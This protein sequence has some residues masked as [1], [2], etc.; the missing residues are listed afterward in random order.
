MGK[1]GEEQP[2]PT[3]VSAQNSEHNAEN[4]CWVKGVV[5]LR[6]VFVLLLGVAVLLSAVFW[7]PPFFRQRDRGDLDL[8]SLFRGGC[9]FFFNVMYW[10]VV[11]GSLHFVL[12]IDL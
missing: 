12:D 6:C 3:S 10:F 2:T 7:L 11:S 5:G 4:H 1:V 8:A 9:S